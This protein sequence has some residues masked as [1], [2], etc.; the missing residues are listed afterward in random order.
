MNFHFHIRHFRHFHIRHT[1]YIGQNYPR[2]GIVHGCRE[3]R[4]YPFLFDVNE[5]ATG[6]WGPDGELKLFNI[7][8][9][10]GERYEDLFTTGVITSPGCTFFFP[11]SP[12]QTGKQSVFRTI[13]ESMDADTTRRDS[14]FIQ[15]SSR[16]LVD[17]ILRVSA[18]MVVNLPRPPQSLLTSDLGD[19][20]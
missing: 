6:T 9:R 13:L 14:L 7:L 19:T 11:Q 10:S 18:A 15:E 4:L 17:R 12:F 16:Q 8:A 3:T 1:H 5:V 2:F 20:S